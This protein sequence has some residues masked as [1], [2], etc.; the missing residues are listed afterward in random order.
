MGP[1]TG[2]KYAHGISARVA[3]V[4][5]FCINS[6]TP[7]TGTRLYRGFSSTPGASVR[8]IKGIVTTKSGIR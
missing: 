3:A 4:I 8:K 5:S 2:R 1:S 7:V 6:A